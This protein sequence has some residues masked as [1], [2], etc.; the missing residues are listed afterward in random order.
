MENEFKTPTP[1]QAAFLIIASFFISIF[2]VV[3]SVEFMQQDPASLESSFL[4]EIIMIGSELGL[5]ILPYLY[6]KRKNYPIKRLF[7]WNGI[8]KNLIWVIILIGL[9][10][11]ILGDELD[12]LV[13]IFFTPPEI[14]KELESF[15]KIRNVVDFILLFT[16]TVVVAAFVE[17]TIFR[18]LL[19]VS[20]ET[21]QNVT[22]AVIYTS[23]AWTII[24]G[25][26][27]WAVQIFLIGIIL[28]YLAWRTKSIIPSVICHGIN[29]GLALL[30]NNVEGSGFFS[31]YEWKGH[32]SPFLLIPAI[33]ILIKGIQLL[34]RYY[35]RMRSSVGDSASSDSSFE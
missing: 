6:L 30:F 29:N 23:L 11:S 34:D 21:H 35:L 16:G 7:R 10:L 1:F 9:A 3:L 5:L 17:E 20:F 19:Q 33:L 32:V 8:D 22:R 18:G 12:R 2:V 25:I 26:L 15:L 27:F 13:N 4:S 28:G 14:L 31:V 24:H